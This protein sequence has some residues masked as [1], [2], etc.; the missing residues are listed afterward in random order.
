LSVAGNGLLTAEGLDAERQT[1]IKSLALCS[2]IEKF[3]AAAI[4]MDALIA[5]AADRR[6]TRRH[7]VAKEGM[8]IMSGG[9]P[10]YAVTICDMSAGGAGF[11]LTPGAG[12]PILL[13]L[14]DEFDLL[15]VK[16]R[17]VYRAKLCWQSGS[18]GGV[19]FIGQPRLI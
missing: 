12:M 5:F 4:H 13:K 17:L 18:C 6:K 7:K 1:G 2:P 3:F 10:E 15:V 8:L 19:R 11:C 14:P 16:E 9:G